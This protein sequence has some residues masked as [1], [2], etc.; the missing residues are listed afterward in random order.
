MRYAKRHETRTRGRGHFWAVH[1]AEAVT[2]KGSAFCGGCTWERGHSWVVC[3]LQVG[4]ARAWPEG[5]DPWAT[6]AGVE[7]P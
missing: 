3:G 6:C 1:T 7:T 4:Y 5:S 2:L